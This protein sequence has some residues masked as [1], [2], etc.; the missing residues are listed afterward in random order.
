LKLKKLVMA[1]CKCPRSP[2][3]S[4]IRRKKKR[5]LPPQH[6]LQLQVPLSS[7]KTQ[8]MTNLRLK[9]ISKVKMIN[10][11][12]TTM[13]KRNLRCSLKLTGSE[14]LRKL[15]KRKKLTKMPRLRKQSKKLT[16]KRRLS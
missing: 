14:V 9:R 10:R 8:I 11:K 7:Q 13:L 6:L 5:L 16:K 4:A 15:I 1:T 3:N 12:M 2:C